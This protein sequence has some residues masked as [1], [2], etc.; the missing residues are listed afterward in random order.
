M[1]DGSGFVRRS[2]TF[3]GNVVEGTTLETMLAGLGAL[4]GA[5]VIMDA[6]IAT[7]DNLAWLVAHGYRCRLLL[8]RHG[9]ETN[10]D[11]VL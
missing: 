10:A 4:P 7:E 5:L 11:Q 9:S 3:A 2:K 6:G 8:K 1:L